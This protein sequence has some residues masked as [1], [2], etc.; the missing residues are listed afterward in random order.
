MNGGKKLNGI[1]EIGMFLGDPLG[2]ENGDEPVLL[3]H[4][5]NTAVTVGDY[6]N[7]WVHMLKGNGVLKETV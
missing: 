2:I 4:E 3:T 1:F 5:I 6:I 7:A